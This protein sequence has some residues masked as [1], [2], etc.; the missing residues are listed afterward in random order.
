MLTDV[1]QTAVLAAD[2]AASKSSGRL[3]AAALIGIAVIVG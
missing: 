2:A 3:V 1:L